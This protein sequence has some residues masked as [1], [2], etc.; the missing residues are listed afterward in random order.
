MYNFFSKIAIL[1]AFLGFSVPTIA[2]ENAEQETTAKTT[3]ET[4]A[5]TLSKTEPETSPFPPAKLYQ[6]IQQGNTAKSKEYSSEII[7]SSENPSETAK[8]NVIMSIILFLEI[9][10]DAP[11]RS[12]SICDFMEDSENIDEKNA[13]AILSFLGGKLSENKL[14]ETL[15]ASDPNWQAT[16]LTAK[17]IKILNDSGV[18]PEKLN[19][20]VK[21]YMEI[22]EELENDAWGNIWK[23]RLI[24]WHNSLQGATDTAILF[25]PLIAKVKEDMINGPIKEQLTT[26][27]NILN[28]LLKNHKIEATR[29]LK[30][31]LILL[32]PKKNVPKN[33]PYLNIL[34]YLDGKTDNLKDIYKATMHQPDFFLITSV[35]IFVKRLFNEKPGELYKKAYLAYLEN[36]LKNIKDSNQELVKQWTPKVQKWK[37]WCDEDFPSS[38]S[39]EPLLAMHSRAI[40]KKKQAEIELKKVMAVYEKIKYYKSFSQ[41]S[42]TDYKKVRTLFKDRPKPAGLNFSSPEIKKYISSLPFDLQKGEW[43]RLAYMRTF[44]KKMIEHLDF[45][46]YTGYITIKGKKIKGQVFKADENYI[47]IKIR[48]SKKKYKWDDF[49][50]EQYITFT[51]SYINRNIGGKNGGSAG[52]SSKN[53]TDKIL[54]KEYRLLAIFCDW[55]GKYAEAI[56]FGKKA[57]SYPTSKGAARQLLLQ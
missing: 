15:D 40:E 49:S 4:P 33:K 35:A 22:S 34:N 14:S 31:A 54:T 3:T 13:I 36:F 46:K 28:N 42:M 47:T 48:R 57:D 10:P 41:L 1:T 16:A 44:K 19:A 8:A 52:F 43:R 30:K 23:Q 45:S 55:Y 9:N 51:E 27:N 6:A 11:A 2:Q 5:E 53:A 12:I 17:Y 32:A 29:D 25:E 37:K 18:D 21:K 24:L 39:L 38:P 50:P 20:C 26:I 56:K 7:F